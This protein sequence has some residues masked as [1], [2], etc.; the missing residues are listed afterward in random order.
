MMALAEKSP[1]LLLVSVV[2][3]VV[4]VL[5]AGSGAGPAW[6]WTGL[7]VTRL[8]AMTDSRSD[9]LRATS[10]CQVNTRRLT[11]VRAGPTLRRSSRSPALWL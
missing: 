11:A 8:G 6:A 4:V 2:V 7:A 1:L 5:V 3:V 10:S 9:T